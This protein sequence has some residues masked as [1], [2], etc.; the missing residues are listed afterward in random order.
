MQ[1][2]A[3]WPFYIDKTTASTESD[4]KSFINARA[5]EINFEI[6]GNGTFTIKIQGRTDV[7]NNDVWFDLSC[8]KLNGLTVVDEIVDTGIYVA[9]ISG[10]QAV[11]VNVTSITGGSVSV[12]GRATTGGV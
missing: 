7:S 8:I 10:V 6:R 3:N 12:F 9:D 2:V 4:M 11:R 5:D 1:V